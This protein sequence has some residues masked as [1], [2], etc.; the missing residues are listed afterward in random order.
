MKNQQQQLDEIL[1]RLEKIEEALN[2]PFWK[3]LS[4][5]IGNHFFTLAALFIVGCFL[6]EL[7]MVVAHL[8]NG[9]N[10]FQVNISH[11]LE[12]LTTNLQDLKF[13]E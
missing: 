6:W 5:W 8:Q 2:P 1:R 4:N 9:F 10:T 11:G 3:R 13:W 12:R 7:W